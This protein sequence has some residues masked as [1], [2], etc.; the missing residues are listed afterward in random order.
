MPHEQGHEEAKLRP[1][2]DS[3][4]LD[5]WPAK[6]R[7]ATFSVAPTGLEFQHSRSTHYS[8]LT[9]GAVVPHLSLVPIPGIDMLPIFPPIPLLE[10]APA[11]GTCPA[12]ML[13]PEGDGPKAG[14]LDGPAPPIPTP[15]SI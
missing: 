14:T 3:F 12:L 10:T 15:R 2:A 7:E 6:F 1:C 9:T 8:D 11:F 13:L 4:H 5:H